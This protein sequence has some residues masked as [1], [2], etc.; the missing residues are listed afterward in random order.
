MSRK[1]NLQERLSDEDR[2]YL[3]SRGRS[4]DIRKNDRQFGESPQTVVAPSGSGPSKQDEGGGSTEQL[5]W[6]SEVDEMSYEE[7][8]EELKERELS[9]AGKKAELQQRLKAAG[10]PVE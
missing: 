6:E 7:L 2:A 5:D 8:Q 3:E 9:A 10:P 1:I 4:G